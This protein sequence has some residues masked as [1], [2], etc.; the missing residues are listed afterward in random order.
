MGWDCQCFFAF[1]NFF[2]KNDLTFCKT[3]Y[4]I[5][6]K[7]AICKVKEG[8]LV[9]YYRGILSEEGENVD[10]K[11]AFGYALG[12]VLDEKAERDEFVD[13][14]FSGKWIFEEGEI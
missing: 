14:F 10:V 11:F 13:W 1:C 2:V 5:N 7:F 12:R 8:V 6:L 9:P 4:I 3:Q